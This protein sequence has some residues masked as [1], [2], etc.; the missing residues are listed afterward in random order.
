[1][2]VDR[3]ENNSVPAGFSQHTPRVIKY[4]RETPPGLRVLFR[5]FTSNCKSRLFWFGHAASGI[6]KSEANFLKEAKTAALQLR[7]PAG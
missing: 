2:I 7:S 4:Y 5:V 6:Q 1:M 3:I